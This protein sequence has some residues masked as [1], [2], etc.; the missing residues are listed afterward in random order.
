[1]PSIRVAAAILAAGTGLLSFLAIREYRSLVDYCEGSPEV[2]AGG[3]NLSCLEP[4]H[5]FAEAAI[6][7]VLLLLEVALLVVLG[8]AVVHRRKQRRA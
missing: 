7:G 3:D 8:A 4:Q 2:A 1:M 6:F 5:W